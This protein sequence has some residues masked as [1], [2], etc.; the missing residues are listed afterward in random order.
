M[1]KKQLRE[2]ATGANRNSDEGKHDI[3]GFVN[4][5][6]E[7]SFHFYMHRHR[8]LENGT[9]RAADN[10]Q[11]GIPPKE[12]LKS[13]TRHFQELRMIE[14]GYS[15]ESGVIEALNAIRFNVEALKLHYL[16]EEWDEYSW[17]SATIAVQKQK[18]TIS[19][20]TTAK[21]N[22]EKALRSVWLIYTSQYD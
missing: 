20:V 10:W 7:E 4:P 15:D 19:S 6:C 14:R 8:H 18:T 5:L 13:L 17:K 11:L 2:F 3:E 12:I 16:L 21:T 9:L 1:P 22:Q